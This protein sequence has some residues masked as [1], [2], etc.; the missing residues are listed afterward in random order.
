MQSLKIDGKLNLN[1]YQRMLHGSLFSFGSHLGG[2][3]WKF[4][5]D[6]APSKAS[7]STKDWFKNEKIHALSRPS[8][9]ADLNLIENLWGYLSHQ[10]YEKNKQYHLTCELQVDIIEN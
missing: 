3:K 2:S 6:N 4:Q 9:S 8:R 7:K 1:S 5:Q 10:V